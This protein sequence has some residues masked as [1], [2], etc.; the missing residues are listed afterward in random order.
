MQ[1]G[2][3]CSDVESL[4]DRLVIKA[5]D[6]NVLR[7]SETMLPGGDQEAGRK[8]IAGNEQCTRFLLKLNEP[9]D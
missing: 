7:D 1:L 4:C 8:I 5:D 9:L 3:Y 2:F 6:C